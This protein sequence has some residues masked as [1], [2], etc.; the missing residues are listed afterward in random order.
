MAQAVPVR[1][2]WD[3]GP[4]GLRQRPPANRDGHAL[5]LGDLI[6]VTVRADERR[7]IP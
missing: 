7:F 4:Y 5:S 2:V 6:Q 3:G 1:R